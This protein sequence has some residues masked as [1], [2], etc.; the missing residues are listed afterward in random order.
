MLTVP[1]NNDMKLLDILKPVAHLIA[2]WAGGYWFDPRPYHTK[3]VIEMVPDATLPG[4]QHIYKNR[5][6]FS[7]VSNLVKKEMDSIRNERLRVI[8]IGLDN[9]LR[10]RP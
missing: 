3:D 4:A 6:G 7:F 5:Y 9:F 2:S 8:N 10:N 1:R